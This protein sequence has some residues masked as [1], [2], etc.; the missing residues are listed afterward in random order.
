MIDCLYDDTESIAQNGKESSGDKGSA[1]SLKS[2][3]KAA[4]RLEK[5]VYTTSAVTPVSFSVSFCS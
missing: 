3:R 5:L 1:H 4:R 2:L